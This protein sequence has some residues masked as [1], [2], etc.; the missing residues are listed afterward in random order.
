MITVPLESLDRK[1]HGAIRW[2]PG[3]VPVLTVGDLLDIEIAGIEETM[4]TAKVLVVLEELQSDDGSPVPDFGDQVEVLP[5]RDPDTYLFAL[6]HLPGVAIL[7][8]WD[9]AAGLP[10]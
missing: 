4:R 6:N 8:V 5:T 3:T 7:P 1:R 9:G 2:E 10:E